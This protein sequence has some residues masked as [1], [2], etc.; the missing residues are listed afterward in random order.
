MMA[1]FLGLGCSPVAS[2]VENHMAFFALLRK[3]GRFWFQFDGVLQRLC[4]HIGHMYFVVFGVLLDSRARDFVFVRICFCKSFHTQV[5]S[6]G[7]KLSDE[8]LA[9]FGAAGVEEVEEG[10]QQAGL[11]PSQEDE[12]VLGDLVHQELL[13]EGATRGKDHLVTWNSFAIIRDQGHI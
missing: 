9:D 10:V 6:K 12:G 7:D 2:I 8:V 4:N 5:L 3:I 1:L 11:N 13:E